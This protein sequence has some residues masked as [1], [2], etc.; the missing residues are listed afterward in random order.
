MTTAPPTRAFGAPS[1]PLSIDES[2]LDRAYAPSAF[3]GFFAD[4]MRPKPYTLRG[5]VAVVTIDGPL[6]TR[7][8]FWCDGYDA[9]AERVEMALADPKASALVLAIDS[10]GGMA[11]GNLD[12]ARQLRALLDASG[13]PCVAHAG[14][15]A[16][17]AAYALACAADAVMVTTDGIVGSIGTIATIYDRTKQNEAEGLNVRV[18]R[19]GT[20]KADP[21]PDVALTD[22]STSRVRT[23][24]NELAAMFAAWVALRRP[25]I[26]DPLALQGASVYAAD[27]VAKGLADATGTLADAISAAAQL[28]AD[29]A[30]RRKT[31]MEDTKA[32]AMLATLRTSAGV[33]TD[34]ELVATLATIKHAAGQL[35]SVQRELAELRAQLTARDAADAAKAR[36][37]VLDKHRERGALTPA[38]EKDEACMADFAPLSAD[39]LDRVL[40][41]LPGVATP[42]T[43]R[44]AAPLTPARATAAPVGDREREFA[45]ATGVPLDAITQVAERDAASKE[46]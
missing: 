42:A 25:A 30:T 11:A 24:I 29:S 17:S 34:E 28:A 33:T 22:A 20:L 39:A 37:S 7:A 27:A 26:G 35:P 36:A 19:S 45:A 41:R 6:D 32:S 12:G 21:H 1:T 46:S 16:T 43:P 44:A 4:E 8:D 9:V 3:G 10:P 31:T 23:R 5:A 18:I 2:A 38:M 15:Q 14:T 40:S 13:K